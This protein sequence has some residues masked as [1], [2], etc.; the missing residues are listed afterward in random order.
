MT[1]VGTRVQLAQYL[2]IGLNMRT[3]HQCGRNIEVLKKF[4]VAENLPAFIGAGTRCDVMGVQPANIMSINTFMGCI[5]NS[6]PIILT[7]TSS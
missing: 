7:L 6:F 5:H 1:I 2:H 4:Q 3:A